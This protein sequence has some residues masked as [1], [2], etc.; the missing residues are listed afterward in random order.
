[1]SPPTY[2]VTLDWDDDGDFTDPGEDISADVLRLEWRLGLET[3]YES[4]AAPIAAQ[5]TVRN[6]SQSYSPEY[7]A[8]DLSPGRPI[9]IQSND[10][11]TTRTH[12][13]GFISRVEPVAGTQG[14]R[15][16]V[17]HAAGPESA[18][19]QNIVRLPPQVNKRADEIIL[20]LL[21]QLFLRQPH[22]KGYFLIGL[23]THAEL[24]TNTRLAETYPRS[25]DIG[26]STFAYTADTW[27]SGIPALDALRQLAD[28]ERGRFFVDMAGKLVFYNRHHALAKV[29]ADAAF[30]DNMEGLDYVYGADVV[31]RIGVRILPRSIGAPGSTLWTLAAS[32]KINPG[33]T[34]TSQIIVHYRDANE[35][36]LGALSAISPTPFFD[37]LANTLADGTGQERTAQIAISL[38]EFSASAVVLTL[39]NIGTD[40]AYL[41]AGARLRGTP[42]IQGDPITLQ[43][44]D[45]TSVSLHGLNGLTLN[46]PALGSLED[47]DQLARFELTRRKD[48]R[49]QVRRIQVSS[50]NL[51][52][53]VLARTLFDRITVTET[54]TDHSADYFII[55]EEHTVDLGS[56]RHEVSWL[57][58]SAAANAFWIVSTSH[59][60]QDAYLAY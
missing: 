53:Q 54:Q 47:A 26:R 59:L 8:N 23:T 51:L 25:I 57:L 11:T 36:P 31:N 60:D 1:M 19:V 4:I 38:S 5:I 48:P 52:T 44:T 45:W 28:S 56:I 9:R 7:T 20:A 49:G 29:S 41:Q 30:A 27:L 58:E 32:Q 55:A 10:G 37:Y 33:E 18:L 16:A 39:R 50:A 24:D 6:P 35:R 12:F 40:V 34:G 14:E 46:L 43:Q 42:I 21:E 3:P 17:I 13:T 22:L 2:T 15:L